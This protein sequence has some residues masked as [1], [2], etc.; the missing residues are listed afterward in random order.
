MSDEVLLRHHYR[1]DPRIIQ[2]NNKKYYNHRLLVD[3]QRS[4]NPPLVYVDV[5]N[6]VSTQKNTAPA[7]VDLIDR[8]LSKHP[9]TSVGIITPFANQREQIHR[10]LTAQEHTNASCG[11][12]HAFQGDEKDVVIFSLALTEQTQPATYDWLKN[13]KE[14]INVATSRA[15]QQLIVL[16]NWRQLERLHAGSDDDDIYEL[17]QYVRSNGTSQVSEKP[18]ASRALGI[19]PYNT[20]TETAFLENLNHALDN[21]FLSG[22]RCIVRHRV[23]IQDLFGETQLDADLFGSRRFDFVVYK[24]DGRRSVPILAIE[25]DGH[26]RH[27]DS[28]GQQRENE[29]LRLCQEHGFELIR[30]A[31]T[32]IR[33][34]HYIKQILI[35]YFHAG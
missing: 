31:P 22:S 3:S 33:R 6:D 14:L 1:C 20:A 30:V 8:Y 11:T 24:R 19:Q 18:A 10:M 9:E 13:N 2:F 32:Y 34:Y 16:S 23:N 25:L 4:D 27:T 15:K 35:R 12:V 26:E 21:V 17:V 28:A 29:K 7:E 5:P